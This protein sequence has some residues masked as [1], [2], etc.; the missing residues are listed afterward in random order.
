MKPT[1]IYPRAALYS[2]QILGLAKINTKLIKIQKK[3][4]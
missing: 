1:E 2:D 3:V 4:E